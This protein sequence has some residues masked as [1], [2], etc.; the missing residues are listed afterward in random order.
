MAKGNNIHTNTAQLSTGLSL[1]KKGLSLSSKIS[2]GMTTEIVTRLFCKPSRQK[3][4]RKHQLFYQQGHT[5]TLSIRG[6]SV[7]V[8]RLG[9]G[10][11]LYLSHGWGSLGYNMRPLVETLVQAGYEVILPDLP[12]HGRSSGTFINQIDMS[13][14]V[15]ELLLHYNSE[16][17][18]E[19]IVTHSWGGTATLLAMDAIRKEGNSAFQVKKMVSISMPS[20]PD[21]IM[22]I[23]CDILGLPTDVK[24]GLC[25]N[26]TAMA[27][28]DGRT[29][30]EAF[31]LGLRDL[32]K[33]PTFEYALIH[34]KKD[35][36]IPYTNSIELAATYPQLRPRFMEGLGHIDILRNEQVHKEVLNHLKERELIL[37]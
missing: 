31:P 8:L 2:T 12:C 4:K 13:K 29:L 28:E 25:Q 36:A 9:K 6:F 32:L 33:N 19:H 23:F 14:V 35:Q 10:T 7:K 5:D 17:P 3:L 18:L 26:L 21:A 20:S 34:G 15:K 22:D 30:E 24:N 11:P 27:G 16:R 37:V 1:M